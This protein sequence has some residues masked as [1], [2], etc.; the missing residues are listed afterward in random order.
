M[1]GDIKKYRTA[2]II[3]LSVLLT[4]T[5]L[6]F[7]YAVIF[8][9]QAGIQLSAGSYGIN[10][11]PYGLCLAVALFVLFTFFKKNLVWSVADTG[12]WVAEILVFVAMVLHVFIQSSID[13]DYGYAFFNLPIEYAIGSGAVTLCWIVYRV[14]PTKQSIKALKVVYY[15]ALLVFVVLVTHA[16]IAILVEMAR[17][18]VHTAPPY[19]MAFIVGWPYLLGLI[20][21]FITYTVL[22]IVQWKKKKKAAKLQTN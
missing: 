7:W 10:V 3:F 2:A 17:E 6:Q 9:K 8:A 5:F 15:L 1:K 14:R 12:F 19:V 21:L 4:C 13:G 18:G 20:A 16:V 22:K 11:I